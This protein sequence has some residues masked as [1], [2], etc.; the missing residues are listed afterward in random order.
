MKLS[1]LSLAIVEPTYPVNV[2]HLARLVK[3]FGLSSLILINP[4]FDMEEALPYASHGADILRSSKAM[5]FKEVLE[6]F[7]LVVGTTAIPGGSR[8]ITRDVVAPEAAAKRILSSRGSV[9]ILF[10][11]E[12]TGLTNEE[13]E[14]CDM[15]IS[16]PTGTAYRTLNVSHAAAIILYTLI[17]TPSL[18]TKRSEVP[19]TIR[20]LLLN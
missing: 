14:L 7:D 12:T 13:L 19:R 5:S 6:R 3:N 9:C 17:A 2:G 8:N 11:R 18:R 20:A 15:V 4:S 16:I 1:N 10:G